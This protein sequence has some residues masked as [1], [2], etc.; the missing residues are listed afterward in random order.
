[1]LKSNT[2]KDGPSGKSID[3]SDEWNDLDQ[4]GDEHYYSETPSKFDRSK[5]KSNGDAKRLYERM[6]ENI[7][8]KELI[9]GDFDY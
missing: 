8:L 2:A 5:R 1:M 4:D 9:S 6:Q 7:R 3:E